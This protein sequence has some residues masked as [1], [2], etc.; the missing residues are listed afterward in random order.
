M[1][2]SIISDRG[3]DNNEQNQKIY[4]WLKQAP[5]IMDKDNDT[6]LEGFHYNAS[7][8][9]EWSK[10]EEL[11]TRDRIL[12]QIAASGIPPSMGT[13]S[14]RQTHM[15]LARWPYN[16]SIEEKPMANDVKQLKKSLDSNHFA[17]ILGQFK[18]GMGFDIGGFDLRVVG[19]SASRETGNGDR[20]MAKIW[21]YWYWLLNSHQE[22]TPIVTYIET[23]DLDL[24]ENDWKQVEACGA[25]AGCHI[26][27]C[28][29]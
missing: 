28:I 19:A 26:F 29:C 24:T 6:S 10:Q 14:K 17:L 23:F 27:Y 25:N 4:N 13:P 7:G 9:L 5:G 16:K 18:D 15:F 2:S 3:A 21:K 1:S 12:H 20:V 11:S 22:N 8:E